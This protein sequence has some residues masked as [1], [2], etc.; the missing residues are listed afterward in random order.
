MSCSPSNQYLSCKHHA[1]VCTLISSGQNMETYSLPYRITKYLTLVVLLAGF[2]KIAVEDLH[3]DSEIFGKAV[4]AAKSVIKITLE[5]LYP[6]SFLRHSM[7]STFL[8][9]SFA[10]A[11]LIN[12]RTKSL[13]FFSCIID[14]KLSCSVPDSDIFL[15]APLNM[16]S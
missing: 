1:N 11:F 7:D 16:R 15:I 13:S 10:A 3:Q 14:G 6:T 9:V 2:Q 8:Y 5:R 12:V 4:D